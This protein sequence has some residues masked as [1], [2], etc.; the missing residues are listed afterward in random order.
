[1]L[2]HRRWTELS[3]AFCWATQDTSNHPTLSSIKGF[4]DKTISKPHWVGRDS[5]HEW[6]ET[7]ATQEAWL[8]SSTNK[9]TLLIEWRVQKSSPQFS[10][11]REFDCTICLTIQLISSKART[12]WILLWPMEW[13]MNEIMND[14]R[15]KG[16]APALF[17]I[18][19][20]L[21][22]WSW[23]YLLPEKPGYK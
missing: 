20:K 9:L 14:W 19:Y 1:M 6:G 16:L 2:H 12:C 17:W 22:F 23:R 18:T 4:R 10:E 3:W 21:H 7:R 15:A 8:Y 5:T 11:A 13:R